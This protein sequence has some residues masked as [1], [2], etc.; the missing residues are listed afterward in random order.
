MSATGNVGKAAA[1]G[2]LLVAACAACCAPLIVPWAIALF[3]TGST[4]FAIA[5]QVDIA[6]VIAL[7]GGA[8]VW[9]RWRVRPQKAAADAHSNCGTAAGC[10]TRSDISTDPDPVRT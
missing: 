3:A 6:T 8:Y 10:C 5:G 2:G 9:W 7:A 1:A 4:G